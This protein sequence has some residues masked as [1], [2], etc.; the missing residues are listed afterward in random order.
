MGIN[1]PSNLNIRDVPG[2][3]SIVG[4]STTPSCVECTTTCESCYNTCDATCDFSL[5]SQYVT[6]CACPCCDIVCSCECLTCHRTVPSGMWKT[7]EQYEAKERDAWPPN[8][9]TAGAATCLCDI[10]PGCTCCTTATTPTGG[11]LLCKASNVAW[12]VAP[13]STEVSRCWDCYGDAITT[14]AAITGCSGWFVGSG[15]WGGQLR[16]PGWSC[17]IYWDSYTGP[18]WT[19][20]HN[21]HNTSNAMY[22]DMGNGYMGDWSKTRT[23]T[24]RAFR[25]VSY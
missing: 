10:N 17:K 19:D 7:S 12:V 9:G 8:T 24:V 21:I 20:E 2:N 13:S 18:Y 6:L 4:P 1:R 25:C 5:G 11:Y 14:A 23:Q 15:G 22:V 16:C 3:G